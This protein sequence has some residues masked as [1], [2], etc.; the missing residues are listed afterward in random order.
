MGKSTRFPLD[1]EVVQ[2]DAQEWVVEGSPRTLSDAEFESVFGVGRDEF[3]AY[4]PWKQKQAVR[5]VG[6][7]KYEKFK[8]PHSK[9]PMA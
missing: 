9:V 8:F 1:K 4:R 5:A 2:D 6:E 3:L 7:P